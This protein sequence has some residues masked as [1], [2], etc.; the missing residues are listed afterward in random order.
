MSA[1][2]TASRVL[3]AGAA[4]SALAVAALY[5]PS[6]HAQS[7]DNVWMPPTTTTTFATPW[8]EPDLRG[9]WPIGHLTGTPLQRPVEMGEREYLTDEEYEQQASRLAA[10][11]A[12]YENEESEG[13]MGMGHWAETGL[14]SRRTSLIVDPPD[15]RIPALTEEGQRVSDALRSSWHDITWNWV[16]DFDTWDR[17]ITRGMPASMLPFMYNNGVEIFQAPGL[18]ALN[19]EMVH[20]T[21]LIPTDGREGVPSSI[22]QWLG[23]SRGHW[24]GGTLVVE[25]TNIRPGETATNQRP[26]LWPVGPTTRIVERFTRTGPASMDYEMTFEDPV[27]YTASWTVKAPWRLDPE[28]GMYEY[29]CHEGQYMIRDYIN[30]SRAAQ[31]QDG[32]GQ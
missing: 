21:R 14:P 13:K 6:A 18:V 23:V 16:T 2:A 31:A 27:L 11:A 10:Q 20:E 12:R 24:E 22:L 7:T 19:M 29:A 5:A 1:R 15:G 3:A 8:G 32:A 4:S 30:A 28:Y 9:K 17:C 25:T 26:D